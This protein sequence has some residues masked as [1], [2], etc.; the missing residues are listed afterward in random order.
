[1]YLLSKLSSSSVGFVNKAMG[2]GLNRNEF[3]PIAVAYCVSRTLALP[4]Q[5]V[6]DL[7]EYY[8]N[9][10]SVV[11]LSAL[12]DIND[13][14]PH[15]TAV[16]R[17]LVE[18]FFSYRY[19]AANPAVIPLAF[20]KGTGVNDFFGL[21]K[22]FGK[23]LLEKINCGAGELSTLISDLT[24]VFEDIRRSRVAEANAYVTNREDDIHVA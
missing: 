10:H 12:G 16:S 2:T 7:T 1:M 24:A 17:K 5:E 6:E 19:H 13:V 11:A 14:L 15:N 8:R 21:S 9:N 23:E 22:V 4:G 20:V 18:D 3:F